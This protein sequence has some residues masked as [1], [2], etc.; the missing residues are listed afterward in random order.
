MSSNSAVATTAPTDRSVP[1]TNLEPI[2]TGN[3][4]WTCS[5]AVK[6]FIRKVAEMTSA[7]SLTATTASSSI[8]E[9]KV[10][11]ILDYQR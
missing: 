11:E 2:S 5:T 3:R 1:K 7:P 6:K 4:P 8:D 10:R 9:G